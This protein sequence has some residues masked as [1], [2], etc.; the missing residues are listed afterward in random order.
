MDGN[1]DE[2]F[3][4]T[5]EVGQLLSDIQQEQDEMFSGVEEPQAE[6]SLELSEEKLEPTPTEK[7]DSTVLENKEETLVPDPIFNNDEETK[8]NKA[9]ENYQSTISKLSINDKIQYRVATINFYSGSS[10]VDVTGLKN[11]KIAKIAKKE[12]LELK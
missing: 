2:S 10:N 3:E 1:G 4:L 6:A 12:M 5:D 9:F 11:K 8:P 7:Y